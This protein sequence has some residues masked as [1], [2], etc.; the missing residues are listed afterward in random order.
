MLRPFVVRRTGVVLGGQ[1]LGLCLS[2]SALAQGVEDSPLS[3]FTEESSSV[4]TTVEMPPPRRNLKLGYK[5]R[6]GFESFANE[7]EQ[8]QYFALSA[9][10][11]MHYQLAQQV[12]FFALPAARVVSQY[13][14]S[15]FGEQVKSNGL[16]LEEAWLRWRV[17]NSSAVRAEIR[18]GAIDQGELKTKLL[19]DKM[20]FPGVFE[21][22][23]FGRGLFEFE[24]SAQQAIP[25]SS[26]LSTKA[27]D[28]EVMPSFLTETAK[29]KIRPLESFKAEAFVTHYAFN[30]LPSAV[31]LES[32]LYGN[33]TTETGPNTARF[34][35]R[36]EGIVA[37][38]RTK[39]DISKRFG[40]GLEGYVVQNTAAPEGYNNGQYI[41]TQ[42][43]IG[44]PGRIDVVPTAAMFFAEDDVAPGFY[45]STR[46]GHNNRQGYLVALETI[47]R[48]PRFKL[49][50]EYVDADV[51]NRSSNQSRQQFFLIRFETLYDFL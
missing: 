24:L 10:L 31:A 40:W 3:R 34:K 6:S 27:V 14:Q 11:G 50:G 48:E 18:A 21:A 47:F 30:D 5:I 2:M 23:S 20:A 32:V 8:V 17:L 44:L 28:A 35:Y 37:G 9:G 13:A 25:T 7:R 46:L 45:N 42:F 39:L 22:I 15:R 38:G 26:T 29:L 49:R 36:F 1:V 4:S 33:S 19:V 51:I 16:S 41:E 43:N 12:D